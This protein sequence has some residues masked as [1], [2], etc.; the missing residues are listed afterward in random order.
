MTDI[1]DILMGIDTIGRDLIERDID[2][3]LTPKLGIP[4]FMFCVEIKEGNS[5]GVRYFLRGF[6]RR[7]QN[8]DELHNSVMDMVRELIGHGKY[9]ED[10]E[11]YPAI[12][13]ESQWI[14]GR[15]R[16]WQK[17]DAKITLINCGGGNYKVDKRVITINHGDPPY[18]Q[19]RPSL[20]SK[21]SSLLDELENTAYCTKEI[22]RPICLG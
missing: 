13:V 12:K 16:M 19:V 22:K 20:I 8:Q 17:D 2:T 15:G 1:T 5:T 3:L 18:G 11:T 4:Y 9:V 21:F 6:E 14:T 10:N 7:Y